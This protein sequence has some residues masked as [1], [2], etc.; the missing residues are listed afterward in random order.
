MST[1]C[2]TEFLAHHVQLLLDSHPEWIVLKT[3][4]ANAFNSLDR[5]QMLAEVAA[6]FPDLFDHLSQMYLIK[7]PLL[8]L[9]HTKMVLL[10]SQQGIHQGDPPGSS[11]VFNDNPSYLDKATV[12]EP[13]RTSVSISR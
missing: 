8:F 2:G 1:K 10:S 7:N 13:W 12:R 6:S 5:H 9:Q 11:I 4:V 3:D